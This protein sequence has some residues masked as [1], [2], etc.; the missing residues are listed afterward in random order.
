M[1]MDVEQRQAVLY[2]RLRQIMERIHKA[3]AGLRR[4]RVRLFD[5]HKIDGAWV[6]AAES[7]PEREDMMEAFVSKF[8]RF[9]DMMGDKLLPAVLAWKGEPNG[10]FIDNL[11]RAERLGLIPSVRRWLEARAMRNT[12]VHEYLDDYHTFAQALLLANSQCHM[13]LQSWRTIQAYVEN[14]HAPE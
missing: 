1:I 2:H 7:V 11:Q 3:E 8:N 12:L 4:S 5:Q 13:L 10:A 6:E 14:G 9:Q